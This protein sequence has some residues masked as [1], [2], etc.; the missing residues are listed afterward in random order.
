MKKTQLFS[1][2]TIVLGA[3]ALILYMFCPAL[4]ADGIGGDTT[5]SGIE[6]MFG[7]STTVLG[8]KVT[9]F[10]FSFL[11]F[12]G[13]IF[14]IAGLVITIL[15]MAGVK[16]KLFPIIALAC[17]VVAALFAFLSKTCCVLGNG[18]MGAG[19]GTSLG[20]GAII[21]GILYILAACTSALP[22]VLKDK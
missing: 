22:L 15:P 11:L 8:T 21:G 6:L 13:F 3:L 4:K 18:D 17:F 1:I 16:F 2:C 10:K 14:A 7:K 9:I 5:Y 12:L 19:S 20:V